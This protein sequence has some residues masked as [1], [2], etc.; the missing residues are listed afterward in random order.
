LTLVRFPVIGVGRYAG[1]SISRH[2][3]NE[4][5]LSSVRRADFPGPE[6]HGTRSVT[7]SVQIGPPSKNCAAE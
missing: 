3:D 2:S 7:E 4:D 1:S 5:P 6:L